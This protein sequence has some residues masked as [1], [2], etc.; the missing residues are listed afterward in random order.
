[1]KRIFWVLL[2]CVILISL[3][4]C[5]SSS[6]ENESAEPEVSTSAST[7]SVAERF[8]YSVYLPNDNADGFDVTTVC[9]E[10]LSAET[11]LTELKNRS[12]LPDMVSVNSF[13]MDIGLITVDFNQAFADA[14]CSTGTSGELMIVGSVVNTFLDAFQA[15][16]LF[17]TVEGQI[18]ESGH[19]VYDFPLSSFSLDSQS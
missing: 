7:E 16:S 8:S 1:M 10:E 3:A 13:R 6:A 11:V 17:F 19:T 18:L 4:A 12:V 5:S 14:V 15:E 2:V 9:A